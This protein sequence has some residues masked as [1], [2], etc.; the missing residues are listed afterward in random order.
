[1]RNLCTFLQFDY[2]A[3]IALQ[4]SPLKIHFYVSKIRQGPTRS[5]ISVVQF[6][7][8]IA[9]NMLDRHLCNFFLYQAPENRD[10]VLLFNNVH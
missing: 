5:K 7:N 9:T 3:K 8:N 2:A 6:L 10:C 4:N 1:M